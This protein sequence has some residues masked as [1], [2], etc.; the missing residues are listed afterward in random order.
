MRRRLSWP[1]IAIPRPYRSRIADATVL[2]PDAELPR[3]TMSVVDSDPVPATSN[4]TGG[5]RLRIGRQDD[6]KRCQE[7]VG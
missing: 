7:V 2:F 1:M 5:R 6:G 3:R 4:G